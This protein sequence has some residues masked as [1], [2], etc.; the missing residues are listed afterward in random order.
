MKTSIKFFAALACILAFASCTPEEN[1][2]PGKN[3][4]NKDQYDETLNLKDAVLTIDGKGGDVAAK[5]KTN[6]DF[7][8]KIQ[9]GIDWVS[10]KPATKAGAPVD[11]TIYFT[12]KE[13]PKSTEQS[14]SAVVTISYTGLSDQALTII[15]TPSAQI[16]LEAKADVSRFSMDGGTMTVD[17]KSSVDYT[18]T[19]DESATEWI[20][21]DANNPVKGD[22]QAKFTITANTVKSDRDAKVTFATE[23]LDPVVI[24]VHQDA[25]T[26]NIG[27]K[28][29]ADFLEFVEASNNG[30]AYDDEATGAKA[31]DLSKWVNEDGEI[32]LLC[33]LDLSSIK[34]WTPIGNATDLTSVKNRAAVA[35]SVRAFGN[36]FNS[37]NGVFNGMNHVI[38][39]LTINATDDSQNYLGFFG[40]LWNATVKNLTFDETCSITINRSEAMPSDTYGFV[41]PA[42]IASTI[43]NVVVKGKISVYKSWDDPNPGLYIGGI[44]GRLCGNDVNDAIIKDC[45]F[46]GEV[47]QYIQEGKGTANPKLFGA[48]VGY[49][50]H[51]IGTGDERWADPNYVNSTKIIN[52]TNNTDI[53]AQIR[54][55]GGIVGATLNKVHIENCINNGEINIDNKVYEKL[56]RAGGIIGYDESGCIVS[57]CENYGNVHAIDDAAMNIGGITSVIGGPGKYTNNKVNCII[58]GAHTNIGLFVGNVGDKNSEYSGNLVKGSV[59]KGYNLQKGTYTN[60]VEVTEENLSEYVGNNNMETN[61]SASF[62]TGVSFWK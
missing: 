44:A 17:I 40:P 41:T 20:I 43:E 42:A 4:E 36:H 13:F 29:L 30:A 35:D 23:G 21:A 59:A 26:S 56:G 16:Y 7:K 52:C 55:L 37:G 25:Y 6:V 12:V 46:E 49:A 22:G 34:E 2:E 47:I 50:G 28:S 38:S 51:D 53:T 45:R 27:I 39:G 24:D 60:L 54:Y 57:G 14:R 61:G 32:C 3:D 19:V 15:Q 33:D 62:I 11:S 5:L 48:I 1:P 18:I 58:A 31:H 8:V 10:Y 9:D